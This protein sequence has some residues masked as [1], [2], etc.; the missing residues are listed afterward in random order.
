MLVGV[1]NLL[2]YNNSSIPLEVDIR[3]LTFFGEYELGKRDTAGACVDFS[4]IKTQDI[5]DEC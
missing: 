5:S 3:F 1:T 2:D 4:M